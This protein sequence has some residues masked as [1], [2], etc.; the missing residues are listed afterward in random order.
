MQVETERLHDV[1]PHWYGQLSP[2]VRT[3]PGN[4]VDEDACSTVSNSR[5]GCVQGVDSFSGSKLCPLSHCRN[6]DCLLKSGSKRWEEK[7][8]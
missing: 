7:E 3:S 5:N 4:K 2:R 1:M 6:E 8:E